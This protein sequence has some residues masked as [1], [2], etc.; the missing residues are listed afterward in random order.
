V[1]SVIHVRIAGREIS[2]AWLV[3]VARIGLEIAVLELDVGFTGYR[4]REVEDGE[5]ELY[6]HVRPA[7]K[8]LTESP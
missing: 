6:R 4:A 8:S 7:L 1:P 2:A 3:G 5:R